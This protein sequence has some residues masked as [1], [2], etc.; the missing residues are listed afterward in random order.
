MWRHLRADR[1][2]LRQQ[3]FVDVQASGRVEDQGR[4]PAR[5][6]FL[7]RRA[8]DLEWRLPGRAGHRDRQLG[9]ER[10]ELLH[11]GRPLR[12]GRREQRMLSLLRVVARQL[13]GGGG[14]AR[15]LEA[16][17]HD[18]R[19]RVRRH[20]E[21]VSAAAEQLDQLAVDD[22]HHL[23]RRRERG[24]DVLTDRPFFH[25]VDEGADHLEVDVRLQE[26]HAD[27][28]ERL[29][30]VLLRQSAAAAELVEDGLQSGTKRV[31]HGKTQL[32]GTTRRIS[33]TPAGP[34]YFLV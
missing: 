25:A 19:R 23:L 4:Q 5:R 8:T 18:D 32:Y 29:L 11:R 16:D 31:E 21:P 30:D 14:L 26:R 7:T 2:Q 12:V 34:V 22:L 1:L 9:A 10:S 17:Q 13:R 28:A 15:A 33:T 27:F 6:R 24:E 20:R 3:D